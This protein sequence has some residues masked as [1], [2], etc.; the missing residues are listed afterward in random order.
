MPDAE[1]LGWPTQK[2]IALLDRIVAASSNKGDLVL[3]PFAGSA[4]ACVA[5]ER[6]ERGWAGIDVDPKAAEITR[7]RLECEAWSGDGQL[8][9]D[10]NVTIRTAPPTRTDCEATARPKLVPDT[11]P[12]GHEPIHDEPPSATMPTS[13]DRGLTR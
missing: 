7:T 3:E 10:R 2:P 9:A 13:A 5:A 4:T 1:R 11:Q 6:L 8:F 12:L